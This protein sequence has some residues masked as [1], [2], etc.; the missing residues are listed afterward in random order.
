MINRSTLY[1]HITLE[2]MNVTMTILHQ[3]YPKPKLSIETHDILYTIY[4]NT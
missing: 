3:M 2:A 1:V 4:R